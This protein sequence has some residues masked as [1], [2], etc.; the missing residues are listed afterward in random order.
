MMYVEFMKF[1]HFGLLS[2]KT[3]HS[4]FLEMMYVEFMNIFSSRRFLD[5]FNSNFLDMMY[6]ELLADFSE[7]LAVSYLSEL[8]DSFWPPEHKNV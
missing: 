8:L 4:C 1:S 7:L 3:F 5:R 2:P 6:V